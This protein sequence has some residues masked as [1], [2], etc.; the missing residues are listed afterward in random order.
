MPLYGPSLDNP[1]PLNRILDAGLASGPDDLAL[2]SLETRWSWRELDAVSGRLAAGYRA[3]GLKPG[4][5]IASLMPNRAAL[6]IHYLACFKAGLV[7]V[8]LNYRYMSPQI[9]HAL[10]VSG[11]RALLAH[12]ERLA[13]IGDCAHTDSLDCGIVTYSGG[14]PGPRSFEELS[15]ADVAPLP[16]GEIDPS[17]PVAIFFTSGSTGPAKGVTHTFESLRWMFASAAAGFELSAQ[18]IM[19]P[20]SSLSHIGSYHFSLGALSLGVTVVVARYFGP[21]EILPLLRQMRP[22]VLCMLPAA[23][24]NIVRDHD[25][26]ADDFSSVRL[27]RSGSDKV[28]AELEKEFTDLTGLVIDE[29]WGCS[30]I[31]LATL[32]PPSGVIKAGSVGKALPGYVLSVRDDGFNE[33]PAKTVGQV[34]A[35]SGSVMSGYWNQ[36]D[37]TAEVIRDGWFNTG[38]LMEADGEGYLYFK[39][40]KKQIIV[41]DGS[42]I[43]PQE[44]EDAL[45]EHEAVDL[46]G[47]VGV[48]DVLHGENVWAYV[49]VRDGHDRPAADELREFARDRIGYKAPEEIVFLDAIP[50]NPTGKVDRVTLKQMAADRHDGIAF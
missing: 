1:V 7:T 24:F 28:P 46:A 23:L 37:A 39:G 31:G 11:A 41:H 36:P 35:R 21:D 27:C 40:R 17:A 45:L 19:L 20:G 18:D 9:D 44:V 33:V 43:S 32:N 47:V 3:L 10:E 2:V 26:T 49:T 16:F 50:L 29:G 8:P 6:V 38:D 15:A 42:N 14:D 22:T 34:W 30:E 48:H 25:V 5:R 12:V 13:D 4:D